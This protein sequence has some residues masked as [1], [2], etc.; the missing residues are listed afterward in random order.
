M[1]GGLRSSLSEER[2][3]G[4]VK[5][6]AKRVGAAQQTQADLSSVGDP[7]PRQVEDATVPTL[8]IGFAHTCHRS[9]YLNTYDD[10]LTASDILCPFRVNTT[11]SQ[12]SPLHGWRS[13]T[14]AENGR[15]PI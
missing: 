1:R 12:H 9:N 15:S 11:A 2:P 14:T 7:D 5:A 13:V 10:T 4:A 3:K 6:R 8:G